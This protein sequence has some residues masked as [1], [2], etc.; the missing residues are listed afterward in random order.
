MTTE[1]QREYKKQARYQSDRPSA[2]VCILCGL[3]AGA[4]RT[5]QNR[6]CSAAPQAR[7]HG[8]RLQPGGSRWDL[9]SRPAEQRLPAPPNT[10]CIPPGR[11]AATEREQKTSKRS[12]SVVVT[13]EMVQSNYNWWNNLIYSKK[14]WHKRNKFSLSV[15]PQ[16]AEL[17]APDDQPDGCR[18]PSLAVATRNR[19]VPL[20]PPATKGSCA[21]IDRTVRECLR[22]GQ[23]TPCKIVGLRR[24]QN[25]LSLGI[26]SVYEVCSVWFIQQEAKTRRVTIRCWM[27]MRRGQETDKHCIH[28][29][30]KGVVRYHGEKI[31]CC[32]TLP[33]CEL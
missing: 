10:V 29:D 11:T 7:M 17:W 25:S 16:D 8:R 4:V 15:L 33:G 32:V 24:A 14:S 9:W 1:L 5:V 3:S 26:G 30:E 18:P 27:T 21:R 19:R 12:P 23:T 2:A 6:Q 13:Q 22:E 28:V 20:P 31:F